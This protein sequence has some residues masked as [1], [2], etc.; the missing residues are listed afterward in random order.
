MVQQIASN[1]LGFAATYV[2][3]LVLIGIALTIRVIAVRREKRIGIGD[4][5]DRDLSK[6]IRVHGNF[7]ETAPILMILLLALPLLGA[8][9]WLVHVVGLAAIV[10]RTM[11][12]IG[13]SQTAGSS[14]GR[15]GGMV[16]TFTAM[17][18]GT[19]GL[20]VLAWM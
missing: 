1:A 6:R 12:A 4:G 3:L 15:V 14:V 11:H 16:L 13:M 8:K 2:A 7:S 18:I 10:G 19:I 9:V 17:L 20:L 5:G